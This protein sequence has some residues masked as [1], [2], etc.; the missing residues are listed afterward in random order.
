MSQP[1]AVSDLNRGDY[2][3]D[4]GWTT[5][6]FVTGV[7]APMHPALESAGYLVVAGHR[8]LLTENRWSPREQKLTYRADHQLTPDGPAA[9][10][11]I[12]GVPVGKE[13]ING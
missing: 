8:Y 2:V 1:T 12:Y 3:W 5:A 11:S 13:P 7:W 9:T 4:I 6:L 10:A